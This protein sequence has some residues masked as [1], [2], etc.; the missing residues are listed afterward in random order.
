[1]NR[2][3]LEDAY[4]NSPSAHMKGLQGLKVFNASAAK[5]STE[6][7]R[8]LMKY[9]VV[10]SAKEAADFLIEEMSEVP[11]PPLGLKL[12]FEFNPEK[13]EAV[14]LKDKHGSVLIQATRVHHDIEDDVEQL[15]KNFN[16]LS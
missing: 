7:L 1:M 11:D 13:K 6:L 12:A 16:R 15:A 4:K 3:N 2:K 14:V 8:E 5:L 10:L 9:G